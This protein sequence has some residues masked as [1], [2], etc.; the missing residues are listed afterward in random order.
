MISSLMGLGIVTYAMAAM[1]APDDDLGR[2]E[3]M[4][5]NMDQWTRFARFHIPKELFGGKENQVFQIPW[6]FGLG[7]FAAAGAQLA[8]V[9]MGKTSLSD[10]LA[11]IF[12][13]ISLDSF[14]PIPVSRMRPSDNPLA[15][16]IDSIVPSAARPLVEF[17]MNKNGLGQDIYNDANRRMGDAYLGGDKIPEVWKDISAYLANTT[18]GAIDLS[19]NS[20]YFLS[21]SYIDGIGRIF[22][23]GYGISDIAQQRKEFNP[24]TDV[25]LFGSFLGAKSSIDTREFAQV[26]KQ[27]KEM[28]RRLNMFEKNPE[29]YAEYITTY[30][31]DLA[32]VDLYNKNVGDELKD[33]RAEA[34]RIRLEK[35][36]S[37]ADRTALLKI[38]KFQQDLI[39]RNMLNT[40]EAY[41]VKP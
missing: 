36:F 4:T 19:P 20:L 11:N 32:V 1:M 2:N 13:Q 35:T 30:P 6:G 9:P 26:E 10:A 18:L 25:P 34:N 12:L 37:P 17:A 40:F 33:L 15:F 29:V 38:N 39:K 14:V 41:D 21:N 28:E 31:F 23:F 22:E 24:K 7:A 16:F 27:I 3:V 8:S 5:D